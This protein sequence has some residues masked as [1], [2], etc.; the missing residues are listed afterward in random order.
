MLVMGFDFGM[1]HIGIATGQSITKTATPLITIRAVD[2]I[3]NWE[4]IAK[5]IEA[6]Q[7]SVIIVGYPLNMDDSSQPLAL[8]AK[9]FANRLQHKFKLPVHLV[10]ERL[11]TWE[12]KQRL[13]I[14]KE[15]LSTKQLSMVNAEAAT[16]L[17]EQWLEMN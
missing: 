13:G 5:L 17:I 10:D 12:A 3:P 15:I 1:K 9:K 16:I 2:G 7:P 6:W 4:E 11:S 8:C 14:H